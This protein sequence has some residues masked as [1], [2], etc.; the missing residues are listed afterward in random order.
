SAA[1]ASP[2]RGICG[3]LSLKCAAAAVKSAGL[4]DVMDEEVD[5]VDSEVA[6]IMALGSAS[7]RMWAISR[8]RYR[9]LIGTKITPS[10]TH[11]RYKLMSSTQFVRYTQR[12][13]PR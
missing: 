3:R 2:S 7:A 13:S 8:S 1:G 11:A 4:M 5:T 9:M 12:R 10:F 6:E